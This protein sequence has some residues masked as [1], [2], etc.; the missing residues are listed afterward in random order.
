LFISEKKFLKMPL[1][2]KQSNGKPVTI[3]PTEGYFP[4][5]HVRV[6]KLPLTSSSSLTDPLTNINLDDY[7]WFSPVDRSLAELILN[8][9]SHVDPAQTLFM[10]R[11]RQEGG[12][13]ISI[14]YNG[15]V[16]HIKINL[17]D[18]NNSPTQ[19]VISN[20]SDSPQPQIS[21]EAYVFSID[22]QHNFDS[23]VALVNYYS[24][25]TLK[26]NFP[27]LDTTL[28]MPYKQA[29]PA[30]MSV[31]VAQHDYD[32]QSMSNCSGEQIELV[33]MQRYYVLKKEPN[34]WWRVFNHDGL[35]GYVPGSY[36]LETKTQAES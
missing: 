12:Y 34:G 20:S 15:A 18:I 24:I 14:K 26:E 35:I 33:K 17:Q 32:P 3:P 6:V 31:A 19:F 27:Q 11:R 25:H 8:R 36:L 28:G 9:L 23:I 21:S 7:P 1:L 30:P 22:Q 10:V 13:A 16:D 5:R 2:S 29:L 4:R